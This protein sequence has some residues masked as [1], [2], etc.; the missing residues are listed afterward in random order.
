MLSGRVAS[1]AR[2]PAASQL[3]D[4]VVPAAANDPS[5]QGLAGW[6]PPRQKK[7]AGQSLHSLLR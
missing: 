1:T 3:L 6:I 5:G 7:V 4:E 2:K